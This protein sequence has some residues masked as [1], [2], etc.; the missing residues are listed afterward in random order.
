[1]QKRR[2]EFGKQ[3]EKAREQAKR[4]IDKDQ[5]KRANAGA[6]D[7]PITSLDDPRIP[8]RMRERIKSLPPEQQRAAFRRAVERLRQ[9]QA[10]P[11]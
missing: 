9:Q 7:G 3:G 1:M 6:P 4:K 10:E 5:E 2:E 8:E 11:K